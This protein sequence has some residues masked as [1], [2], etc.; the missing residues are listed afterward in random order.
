MN[1]KRKMGRDFFDTIFLLSKNSK[2]D[3]EY[4]DLKLGI[5][6]S[7]QLKERVLGICE[8]LDM[9]DMAEDVA[10]F[11]FNRGDVK[12]VSLFADYFKQVEL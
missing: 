2:P 12:K 9:K 1:R 4:L 6:N 5:S 3:Y 11:L 10:P 7:R 8:N